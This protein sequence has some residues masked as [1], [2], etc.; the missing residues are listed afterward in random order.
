MYNAEV[1]V[2][3][4]PRLIMVHLKD[5]KEYEAIR[6]KYNKDIVVMGK[7]LVLSVTTKKEIGQAKELISKVAKQVG[8]QIVKMKDYEGEIYVDLGNISI[9]EVK[10]R[11]FISMIKHKLINAKVEQTMLKV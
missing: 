7:N 5:D 9:N 4:Y 10:K 6:Y 2:D 3:T 8:L 11:K 1:L